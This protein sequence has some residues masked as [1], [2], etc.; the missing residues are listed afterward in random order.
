[1]R[2]GIYQRNHLTHPHPDWDAERDGDPCVRCGAPR[3]VAEER[4]CIEPR[5][6]DAAP[7]TPATFNVCMG[8]CIHALRESRGWSQ[9]KLAECLSRAQSVVS[10]WESGAMTLDVSDLQLIANVFNCESHM[11]LQVAQLT[12]RVLPFLNNVIH[13]A[14]GEAVDVE[15]EPLAKATAAAYLKAMR[16]V[17]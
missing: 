4:P 11:L 10:K 3:F 13:E 2:T 9:S 12:S 6:S 8:A 7:P 5:T 16:V 1:M 17:P 14:V 15:A